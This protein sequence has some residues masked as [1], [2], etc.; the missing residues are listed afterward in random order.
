MLDR[1]KDVFAQVFG[2]EIREQITPEASMETIKE[3][4][5]L[6][7]VNVMLG[8]ESEFAISVGPDDAIRLTSIEGI[9]ALVQEKS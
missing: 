8:L 2:E 7:F 6:S 5:S 9:L 3:W 1:V 4:D